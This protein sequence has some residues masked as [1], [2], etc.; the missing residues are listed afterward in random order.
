MSLINADF[1]G[2]TSVTEILLLCQWCVPGLFYT[3][4]LKYFGV[5]SVS[6]LFSHC[7]NPVFPLSAMAVFIL[8]SI[9][10]ILYF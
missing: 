9:K 7:V 2:Q 1:S 8:T 5:F 6:P 4:L 3:E 10:D